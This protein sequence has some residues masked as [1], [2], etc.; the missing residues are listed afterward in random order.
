LF[1]LGERLLKI[2][3]LDV[4]IPRPVKLRVSRNAAEE[5]AAEASRSLD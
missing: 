5:V 4:K 2:A 1:H 3:G